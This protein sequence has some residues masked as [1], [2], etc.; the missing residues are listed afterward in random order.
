ML[1][2]QTRRSEELDTDR[3]SENRI[4]TVSFQNPPRT[5]TRPLVIL[6]WSHSK[7][8]APLPRSS[9]IFPVLHYFGFIRFFSKGFYEI[10]PFIVI[11]GCVFTPFSSFVF[12]IQRRV[13]LR[14]TKTRNEHALTIILACCESHWL[15]YYNA[16]NARFHSLGR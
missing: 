16:E 8:K 10:L 4:R 13:L 5:D 1:R 2:E 7:A 15:N 6:G 14:L 9:G 11:V 3:T 12:Y